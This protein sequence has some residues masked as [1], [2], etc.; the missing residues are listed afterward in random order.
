MSETNDAGRYMR[1]SWGIIKRFID[2]NNGSTDVNTRYVDM[3]D[4]YYFM[5]WDGPFV[6]DCCI[7]KDGCTPQT[8]FEASYKTNAR[9]TQDIIDVTPP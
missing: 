5:A 9:S 8:Q 2:D 4:R 1:V 6:L 3:G 7:V